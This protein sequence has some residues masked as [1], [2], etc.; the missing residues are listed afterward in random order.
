MGIPLNNTNTL[1]TLCFAD[2]QVVLAQDHD[3]LEYMFNR[4]ISKMGAGSKHRKNRKNVYRRRQPNI[5]LEDEREIECCS[6]YKYLG[7]RITNDG[8]LDE[9]IKERNTQGRQANLHA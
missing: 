3:D 7:L 8:T 1:Y 9:V 5:V 6:D 4:R 2:T